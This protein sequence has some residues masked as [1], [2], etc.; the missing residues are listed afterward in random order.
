MKWVDIKWSVLWTF[1]IQ[2]AIFKNN[3]DLQKW[4]KLSGQEGEYGASGMFQTHH[5]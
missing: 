4:V 1:I 3:N 5:S 2:I